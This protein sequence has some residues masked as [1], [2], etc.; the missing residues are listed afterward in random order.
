MLGRR[1]RLGIGASR[2]CLVGYP[3]QCVA[4]GPLTIIDINGRDRLD[5]LEVAG[6]VE[7]VDV[8]QVQNDLGRE[9]PTCPQVT[10]S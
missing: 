2:T 6:V 8:D 7:E 9:F 10:F 5:G 3:V 1:R 4:Q